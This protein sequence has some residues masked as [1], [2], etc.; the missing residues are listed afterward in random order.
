MSRE[1]L[2]IDRFA[3]TPTEVFRH[4]IVH[5]TVCTYCVVYLSVKELLY[6]YK[7][8]YSTCSANCFGVSASKSSQSV[9]SKCPLK[10]C[11][12]SFFNQSPYK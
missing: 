3:S 9:L 7:Y 1:R 10:V 11:P 5:A 12:H 2:C 6:R 8:K 4:F